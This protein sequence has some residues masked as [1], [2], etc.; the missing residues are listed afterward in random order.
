MIFLQSTFQR[1][2]LC[3][4]LRKI[5][6]DWLSKFCPSQ[7]QLGL[8]VP[9]H[10]SRLTILT[11]LPKGRLW[12]YQ[13]IDNVGDEQGDCL[14]Q[15]LEY[16]TDGRSKSAG[17]I[18]EML[19]LGSSDQFY[20]WW[21]SQIDSDDIVCH[22]CIC[23]QRHVQVLQQIAESCCRDTFLALPNLVERASR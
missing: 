19:H 13:A 8:T 5:T 10:C 20:Q 3:W 15:L 6:G 22:V 18:C 21:M 4:I 14:A 12:R 2:L 17:L 7:W 9:T 16:K 1:Q 11:S 23:W